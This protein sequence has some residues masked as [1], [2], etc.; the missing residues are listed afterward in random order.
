MYAG[1]TKN[2][3]YFQLCSIPDGGAAAAVS[4][5]S[6]ADFSTDR[7]SDCGDEIDDGDDANQ[8]QHRVFSI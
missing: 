1:P 6:A 4:V 5:S 7:E 8:K 2:L 3:L